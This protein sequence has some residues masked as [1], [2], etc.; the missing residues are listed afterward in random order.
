MEHEQAALDHTKIAKDGFMCVCVIYLVIFR[1]QNM[2][3]KQHGDHI[4]HKTCIIPWEVWNM[5]VRFSH[6]SRN[7][8]VFL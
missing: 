3:L 5:Q 7:N 4:S 1:R 2:F 6:N 8:A